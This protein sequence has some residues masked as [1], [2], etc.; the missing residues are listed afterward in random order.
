MKF[1]NTCE[2]DDNAR[3]FADHPVLGPATRFLQRFRDLIDSV[4]DG[5]AY[6]APPVRSAKSLMELIDQA[7]QAVRDLRL[8]RGDGQYQPS[9][10]D[11]KK[12]LRPVKAFCTRH[13]LQMP[14]CD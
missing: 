3:R 6:W 4:S 10:A 11:L 7:D 1:H 5:W 12:A 2:I 9:E 14:A 8:G 13:K